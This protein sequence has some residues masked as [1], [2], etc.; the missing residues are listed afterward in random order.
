LNDDPET[1][2]TLRCRGAVQKSRAVRTKPV[3][4]TSNG[5]PPEDDTAMKKLLC[6][7]AMGFALIGCDTGEQDAAKLEIKSPGNITLPVGDTTAAWAVSKTAVDARGKS[8]TTDPYNDFVLISSDSTVAA[9]VRNQ[10]VLGVKAGTATITASDDLSSLK[11][12]SG[13]TVTVTAR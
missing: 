8:F 13:V 6:A 11:S 12:E 10:R 9:I 4:G 3:P 5:K 2:S 1:F 7:M